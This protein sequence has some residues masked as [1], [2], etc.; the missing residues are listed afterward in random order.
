MLQCL[1]LSL[2]LITLAMRTWVA[3]RLDLFGDE[4]F[5]WQCSRQLDWAF[6]DHPLGT[7]ALVRMGTTL[8]GDTPLAVRSLFLLCSALW[9]PLV[10]LLARPRV[11]RRQAWL[12]AGASQILPAGAVLGAMAVPDIAMITF[13]L[14]GLV[15]LDRAL[16]SGRLL[17]WAIFGA[18][19]AAG[20]A[21]HYRFA[22][23][24]VSALVF[25][26]F[27]SV[28]RTALRS[29]GAWIGMGIM[30]LGLL[31]VA[32]FNIQHAFRPLS[33]QLG[34]R[35]AA[36]VDFSAPLS[37]VLEQAAGVTPLLYAALFVALV[38]SSRRARRG[39]HRAAL[40]F[41]FALMPLAVFLL[42]SPV[43]DSS[44]NTFH[45]PL[46]GYFPLLVFLPGVLD[47]WWQRGRLWRLLAWGAPALAGLL[48]T[49]VFVDIGTSWFG[50][51]SLHKPFAGWSELGRRVEAH[52]DRL[53]DP[54]C[55]VVGDNYIVAA[56]TDFALGGRYDVYVLD[57]E[58]NHKDGRALQYE[59]WGRDEAGLLQQP[60]AAALVVLEITVTGRKSRPA[61]RERAAA[62]FSTFE[63]IDTLT[64]ETTRR[65]R[66]FEFYAARVSR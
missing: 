5:Y 20:L 34:E 3:G 44:H 56:E 53:Q 63:R 21:T 51:R 22:L 24:P 38:A 37:H 15:A 19:G 9:A 60:G 30:G 27:T 50:F 62:L 25:L 11:D 41:V 46:S 17:A 64:I 4:A 57:H 42:A 66:V 55:L 54:Q 59:I 12:A 10:Y 14:L 65:P 43:T 45:W 36:S 33:Y 1:V 13:G 6:A 31:P 28:G 26:L 23:F 48:I 8:F 7:A 58:L 49:M 2:T 29:S 40:L 18:A 47:V 35:H 32:M 39:D 52:L 16:A 61:W